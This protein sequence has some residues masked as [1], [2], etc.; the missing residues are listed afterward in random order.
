[1]DAIGGGNAG[2]CGAHAGSF[3]GAP[4]V[5]RVLVDDVLR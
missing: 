1:V 2:W 3:R 5:S 4:P